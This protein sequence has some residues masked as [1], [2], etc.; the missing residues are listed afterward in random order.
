[1]LVI[2]Q[3]TQPGNI[4]H[5]TT[6]S[7]RPLPCMSLTY[8]YNVVSWLVCNLTS[9]G[10]FMG[11]VSNALELWPLLTLLTASLWASVI[12][13]SQPISY[14][15]WSIWLGDLF[16]GFSSDM[17]GFWHNLFK[18]YEISPDHAWAISEVSTSFLHWNWQLDTEDVPF[19]EVDWLT[20]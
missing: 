13:H 14:L 8:Q 3:H 12:Y 5:W 20:G 17:H 6:T 10:S 19:M 16:N 18:L 4:R 11:S 9:H 15:H 7:V 2:S 1:M